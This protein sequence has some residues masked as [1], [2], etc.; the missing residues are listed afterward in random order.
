MKIRAYPFSIDEQTAQLFSHK[1]LALASGK[2]VSVKKVKKTSTIDAISRLVSSA[3]HLIA[4][5][6]SKL[7][8][9]IQ[10]IRG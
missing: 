6:V 2:T 9:F 7:L 4:E 3:L 1:P 8:S 10:E 5:T